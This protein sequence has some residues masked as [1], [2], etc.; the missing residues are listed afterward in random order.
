MNTYLTLFKLIQI[1]TKKTGRGFL[2]VFLYI[3]NIGVTLSP[4]ATS[5]HHALQRER[6]RRHVRNLSGLLSEQ[7]K[8]DAAVGA[9]FKKVGTVGKIVGLAMFQHK[10]GCL[11]LPIPSS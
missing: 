2:S 3:C 1:A 4:S 8:V 7:T 10:K 11:P 9:V 6:L 5:R